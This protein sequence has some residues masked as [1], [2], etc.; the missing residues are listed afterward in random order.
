[1]SRST[2]RS[3]ASS[4]CALSLVAAG[5]GGSTSHTAAEVA[6]A[7]SIAGLPLRVAQV[8]HPVLRVSRSYAL[9]HYTATLAE[10]HTE[11]ALLHGGHGTFAVVYRDAY[12]ARRDYR[13]IN[14]SDYGRER[15]VVLHRDNVIVAADERDVALARDALARL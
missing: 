8:P 14:R 10:R 3:I 9:A 13:L 7:F 15:L 12:D 1:V 5:C 2:R 4:L 6:T 11:P